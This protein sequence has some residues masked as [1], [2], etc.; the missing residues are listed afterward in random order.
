MSL[1]ARTSA[2]VLW[3]FLEQLFTRGISILVTLLLARFLTPEDYGLVATMAV[4]IAIAGA[5]M[6][7]GIREA[8]IRKL[9]PDSGYFSTAFYANLLLSLASYA[10]LYI[11]APFIASFYNE[12]LLVNLVRVAGLVVIV[13]A[14]QS[15]QVAMLSRELLSNLVYSH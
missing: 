11:S 2:G 12:P 3:S 9:N 15:I 14:F 10:F 7:S 5:I 4:F 13:N 8:V 6:E 1:K